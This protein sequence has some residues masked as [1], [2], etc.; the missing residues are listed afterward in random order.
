MNSPNSTERVSGPGGAP[1][2]GVTLI[3][4]FRD[5]IDTAQLVPEQPLVV[6]REE[7]AD[8][9]VPDRTLSREHARF[10]LLDGRVLVEDL[11]SKNGT[12]VALKRIERA[13]LE[14]GAE[15][16]LGT[17]IVRLLFGGVPEAR[18]LSDESFRRQLDGELSR[19]QQFRRSFA[20]L[21]VRADHARAAPGGAWA[22]RLR[23]CL[24]PVDGVSLY[25]PGLSLVLLPET[26]SDVALQIAGEIASR[27]AEPGE[28]R[29]VGV[30]V[31]PEAAS[32]AGELVDLARE[33]AGRAHPGSSVVAAST[34]A[35]AAS[36]AGSG[37]I[38]GAVLRGVLGTAKRVASSQIPV[39]LHG[40]T[41]TGKELFANYIHEHG[42]RGEQPLIRVNCSAIPA[43]LV[44]ST[45]FGHARGAFTGAVQRGRGFFEEADKGTIFL[46]EIGE[47]PAAAQAV[48]L[49]VLEEGRFSRVGEA[50]ETQVDVRIIAAT[51]RDLE[52]MVEEG[53]FRQDLYYRLSTMVLEIPP[54]RDRTDEIEPLVR[55]FLQK[56]NETHD[57]S[58]LRVA[59]DA[60]ALLHA[61]AWPGN[62][63]ELRNA[64]DRAVVLA[65]ENIIQPEDLP[66]RVREGKPG[67]G[68]GGLEAQLD[69]KEAQGI[70]AAL[71][72]TNWNITKAAALL[73]MERA[74]L[75]R[76]MKKFGIK[77]P[78]T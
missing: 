52:A 7:P 21:A 27:P 34:D 33:A 43:S 65:P 23:E 75:R 28:I 5:G 53:S 55:L 30:A 42:P 14:I 39:L 40:E 17:V 59:D 72:K 63:R 49:R 78:K 9:R 62:V 51:H 29:L 22:A 10:T 50:Q 44:E 66:D 74:K 15:V 19:A 58:V 60:M 36:T 47:L 73:P 31:Y 67:A 77:K 35:W 56:A 46:D 4:Y 54:L 76:R 61:Y 41:G 64:I 18:L 69:E 8:K 68:N 71:Q 2:P 1:P 12:W 16:M 13:E 6:G 25:T 32:T 48:L 26:G 20:V 38:A 3:I 70:A 45:L 37:M 24:R 57:R 11:G